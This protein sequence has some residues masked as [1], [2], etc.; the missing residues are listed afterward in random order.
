[1]I[2]VLILFGQPGA[3]KGTIAKL[4]EKETKQKHISTGDIFRENIKNETEL[5][6]KVSAILNA[7]DYVPD[8]L[9]NEILKDALLKS[10]VLE[11]GALLD[12]Y[13]RT[14][15]QVDFLEQLFKENN[16]NAR[17]LYLEAPEEEIINR[18]ISRGRDDDNIEIIKHR[19]EVYKKDSAPL[20]DKLTKNHELIKVDASG[21]IDQ[22]WS[23][24]KGVLNI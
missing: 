14:S 19:F 9:T 1:M 24:V 4:I 21:S 18:L 22:V 11:Y 8:E 2:D 23:R 13:P 7:G 3:G 10:K 12:G 6:K 5:G 16:F 15:N 20:V 17:I